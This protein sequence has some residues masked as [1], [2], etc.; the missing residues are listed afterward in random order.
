MEER[1]ELGVS[2]KVMLIDTSKCIAC[3]A[4]Q[5][6]CQQWHQLPAEA[7]QFLGTYQ[8]PPDMSAANLTIVKFQENFDHCSGGTHFPEW[9]FFKDQCRHCDPPFCKQACPLEPK[10]IKRKNNGIVFI[11][12]NCDPTACSTEPVKPC[13]LACP[14]KSD[15]LPPVGIPRY[16]LN[17][18]S[19]LP[20]GRANK[21]DMCYDRLSHSMLL[22]DSDPFPP[23]AWPPLNGG[24]YK[25]KFY[26]SKKTACELACPTRAIKTGPALNMWQKA[27]GRKKKLINK[28]GYPN[29]NL[30]PSIPTHVI[31]ILTE[32]PGCYNVIEVP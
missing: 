22:G 25:G 17:D 26:K 11:K 7:T 14:F 1:T 3:R 4:C 19:T 24:R 12:G 30:Y 6:A 16:K 9:L 21:C 18:S 15:G 2:G 20:D 23:P 29:A 10:A 27:K 8:N 13:Q 31:W 5:I 28:L 32:D